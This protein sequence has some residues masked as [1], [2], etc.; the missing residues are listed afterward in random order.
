MSLAVIIGLNGKF[1][2]H[3]F[4]HYHQQ[5]LEIQIVWGNG[6]RI[7]RARIYNKM[8]LGETVK[9][10][11]LYNMLLCL[12]QVFYWRFIYEIHKHYN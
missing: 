11:V 1:D 5:Y 8:S 7:R 3:K 4:K 2:W 6:I 12:N 9:L 10:K